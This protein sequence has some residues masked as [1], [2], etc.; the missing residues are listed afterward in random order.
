M[1]VQSVYN[2]CF[3]IPYIKNDV[4]FLS[5]HVGRM[6]RGR[7]DKDEFVSCATVCMQRECWKHPRSFGADCVR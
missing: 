5:S 2:F 3:G 7:S 6:I 1:G 4:L